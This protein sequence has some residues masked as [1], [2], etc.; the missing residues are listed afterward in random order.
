MENIGNSTNQKSDNHNLI[1]SISKE[2]IKRSQNNF[3]QSINQAAQGNNL[4]IYNDTE[5]I[6]TNLKQIILQTSLFSKYDNLADFF[7]IFPDILNERI[8]LENILLN[9]LPILEKIRDKLFLHF[10][11]GFNERTDIFNE[12]LVN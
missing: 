3:I 6:V 1:R 5:I 2:S 8:Y 11:K 10:F 12:Y 7:V 9:N 4:D